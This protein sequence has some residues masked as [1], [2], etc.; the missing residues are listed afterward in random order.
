MRHRGPGQ[1]IRRDAAETASVIG[2]QSNC[3]WLR[4]SYAI[5]AAGP[6]ANLAAAA[7]RAWRRY[8]IAGAAALFEVP[9]NLKFL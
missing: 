2:T 1:P 9:R 5:S 4:K 6:A 7:G 3:Q 8:R